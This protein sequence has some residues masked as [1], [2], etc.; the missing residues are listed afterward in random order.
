LVEIVVR[1]FVVL[2][3]DE[4]DAADEPL[5]GAGALTVIVSPSMAVMVPLPAGLRKR[6]RPAPA[7]PYWPAWF[8]DAPFPVDAALFDAPDL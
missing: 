3:D 6:W 7:C 2:L 4:D 8:V 5:G 1:T